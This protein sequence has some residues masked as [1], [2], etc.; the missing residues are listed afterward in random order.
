MYLYNRECRH[1]VE[2]ALP[3]SSFHFSHARPRSFRMAGAVPRYFHSRRT[4]RRAQADMVAGH[5]LHLVVLNVLVE[6]KAGCELEQIVELLLLPP[7][8]LLL[9]EGPGGL[10]ILP[11][12]E[13]RASS[14]SIQGE[15]ASQHRLFE[16]PQSSV[17]AS[18]RSIFRGHSRLFVYA[19]ALSG[20]GSLH[21][22]KC[23]FLL[24]LLVG[25]SE[26]PSS[27]LESLV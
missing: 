14:V 23:T 10:L 20:R 22:K 9:C 1:R 13:V 18:A 15:K 16:R 5:K 12:A 27:L 8:L 4:N 6:V 19:F 11:S 25:C 2:T 24:R 17:S 3:G 26:P 21:F 7:V